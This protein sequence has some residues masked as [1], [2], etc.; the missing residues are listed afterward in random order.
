MAKNGG[1]GTG[2]RESEKHKKIDLGVLFCT[3]SCA[4]VHRC[5]ESFVPPFF[6]VFLCF[7]FFIFCFCLF[8]FYRAVSFLL[9]FLLL[10]ASFYAAACAGEHSCDEGFYLK[11]LFSSGLVWVWN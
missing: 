9:L 2:R 8:F 4:G 3:T 5:D 10:S 6:V 1:W 7:F 11:Y